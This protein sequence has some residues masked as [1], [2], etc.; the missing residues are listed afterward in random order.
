[1]PRGLSRRRLGHDPV[2]RD[3]PGS[4]VLR[5]SRQEARDGG[6][7]DAQDPGDLEMGPVVGGKAQGFLVLGACDEGLSSHPPAGGN[8]AGAAFG[9]ALEDEGALEL[10]E[11][12]EDGEDQA[13]LGRRGVGPLLGQRLEAG[14][15]GFNTGDDVV[16]V[17]G[18]SG[19]AIE[20]GDDERVAGT[21]R[22]EGIFELDA[23]GS[24]AWRGFLEKGGA[25]DVLQSLDLCGSG[26]SCGADAGV[27]D[28]HGVRRLSMGSATG[29]PAWVGLSGL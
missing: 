9:G 26:L 27:S 15:L 29:F 8:G 1:M 6:P 24:V 3:R 14:A 28:D 16:E 22:V 21:E 11:P 12:A 7:R 25:A 20:A 19:K 4:S 13:S 5:V 10:G 2:Q 18:G 17:S 23:V